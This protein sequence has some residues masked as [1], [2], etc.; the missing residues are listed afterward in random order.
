MCPNHAVVEKD[1]PVGSIRT[2]KHNLVVVKSGIMN[3]G[4]ESG[5]PIIRE[6][7]KELPCKDQCYRLSSRKRLHGYREH[8]ECGFLYHC[9]RAYY[10][11]RP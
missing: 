2:G 11:R 1:Y 9:C 7:L 4:E 8:K 3:T 10:F 6:L 5:V